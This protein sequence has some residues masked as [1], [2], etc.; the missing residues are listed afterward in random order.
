MVLDVMALA[1]HALLARRRGTISTLLVASKPAFMSSTSIDY[2]SIVSSICIVL[3]AFL[4]PSRRANGM[5][6]GWR[7]LS[8]ASV[9]Y[10]QDK[11]HTLDQ[12]LAVAEE[13]ENSIAATDPA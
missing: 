2:A 9:R 8:I 10:S 4:I 13:C 12:L 6:N 11:A 7:R 5:R 3:L 1:D